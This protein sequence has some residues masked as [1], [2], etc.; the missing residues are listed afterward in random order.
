MVT[1]ELSEIDETQREDWFDQGK[2]N[3]LPLIQ[4]RNNALARYISTKKPCHTV[5]RP[6]RIPD[7]T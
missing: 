1:K 2:E 5:G 4:A 7:V 3:L 6:C